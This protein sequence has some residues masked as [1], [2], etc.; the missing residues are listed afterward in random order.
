M[1]KERDLIQKIVETQ[2]TIKNPNTG[3]TTQQPKEVEPKFVY[4]PP[5]KEKK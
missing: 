1:N 5:P 3:Q 2:K 4:T